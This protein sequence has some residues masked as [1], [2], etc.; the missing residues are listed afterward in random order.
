MFREAE[1]GMSNLY[2]RS[3]KTRPSGTALNGGTRVS[4]HQSDKPNASI[5]LWIA[6]SSIGCNG[7]IGRLCN[8]PT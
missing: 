8:G 7:P 2:R 3:K 5:R 6:S 1:I 4:C